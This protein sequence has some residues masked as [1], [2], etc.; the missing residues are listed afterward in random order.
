MGSRVLGGHLLPTELGLRLGKTPW[1]CRRVIRRH[2]G[3]A[4]E[5]VVLEIAVLRAWLKRHGGAAKGLW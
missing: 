3:R 1:A 5:V 4:Q 2:G